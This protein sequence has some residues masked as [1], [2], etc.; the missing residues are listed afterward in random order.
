M[1][2]F[3]PP[4]IIT[5]PFPPVGFHGRYVGTWRSQVPLLLL[6]IA[7]AEGLVAGTHYW[8]ARGVPLLEAT[9]LPNSGTRLR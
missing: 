1:H 6:P 3:R 9:A 7:Y 5:A 8:L 4:S 2:S